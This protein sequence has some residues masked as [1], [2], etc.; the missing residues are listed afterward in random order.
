MPAACKAPGTLPLKSHQPSAM[1]QALHRTHLSL[2]L[3]SH[4]RPE[5]Q[6]KVNFPRKGSSATPPHPSG[7]FKWKDYCPKVFKRLRDVFNINPAQY[8]LSICG[9]APPLASMTRPIQLLQA[10]L[11]DVQSVAQCLLSHVGWAAL[12]LNSCQNSPTLRLASYAALRLCRDAGHGHRQQVPHVQS[13]LQSATHLCLNSGMPKHRMTDVMPGEASRH[14]SC[15]AVMM[16]S[17][18]LAGCIFPFFSS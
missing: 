4:A 16:P 8:M 12:V 9:T 11:L 17:A 6:V 3:R 14:H 13:R 7:D 1:G 18:R 2:F 10:W 5:K 15:T